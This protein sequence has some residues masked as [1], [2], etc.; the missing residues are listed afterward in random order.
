VLAI[1]YE[2][3]PSSVVTGRGGVTSAPARTAPTPAAPAQAP[4]QTPAPVPKK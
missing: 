3:G 4:A 2:R 1:F